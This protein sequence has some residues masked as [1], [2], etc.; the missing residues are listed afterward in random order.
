VKSFLNAFSARPPKANWVQDFFTSTLIELAAVDARYAGIWTPEPELG[1]EKIGVSEQFLANADIYHYRYS[2]ASYLVD[3]LDKA[4]RSMRIRAL[5]SPVILDI[6]TG[7][8]KNSLFPMLHLYPD[9]RFV[10][11]DLSPD[12][13]VILHR[14]AQRQSLSD[15]IAC[16]CADAT[17]N[18]FVPGRFDIVTGIAILHHLLDPSLAIKAAFDALKDDGIA[19]FYEPFEAFGLITMAYERILEES[20][21]RTETIDPQAVDLMRAMVIDINARRGTDK[22]DVKFRYMDDKWL[23][24]RTYLQDTAE[25]AGFRST[26]VIAR[27]T[28]PDSF[29]KQV[30]GNLHDGRGLRPEALPN[31]AWRH[32]DRLD[33]NFS[34]EMKSDLVLTGLVVLQKCR[35]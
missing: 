5:S 1:A 11:T 33:E 26:R 35:A 27:S 2:H 14:Y 20:A 9:A 32:I 18:Y 3:L 19:I 24:T 21:A 25:K 10:A 22:S 30:E 28:A 15:R 31:W 34:P 29:R 12:L 8:G 7:S 13:L 23:F 4:L 16:V 6:G 17:K